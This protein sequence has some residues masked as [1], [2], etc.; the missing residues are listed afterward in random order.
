M[1]NKCIDWLMF[2][3][4]IIT[5][6]IC[7][8]VCQAD[9]SHIRFSWD[10]VT[11][12]TDNEPCTDLAG[13]ALYRSRETN[14]WELFTGPESAY[15]IVAADITFLSINCSEPGEWYWMLRAFDT[16]G[17]YSLGPSEIIHTNIDITHPGNVFHF[18]TC[19]KGDINCDG[20]INSSDI[21]E[22]LNV[23]Q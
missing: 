14:N 22:F 11:L 18:R 5:I 8:Q 9:N 13:Y 12:S 21:T 19:Q 1:K 17:N 7:V 3:C 16:S 15:A 20:D 4:L 23:I 10:A 2:L 6:M